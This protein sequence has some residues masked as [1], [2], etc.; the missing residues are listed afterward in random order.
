M[1]VKVICNC[2]CVAFKF[3]TRNSYVSENIIFLLL[4]SSTE[5]SSTESS[6][7]TDN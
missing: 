1:N 7:I 6:D 5:S 4:S 3:Y 2:V